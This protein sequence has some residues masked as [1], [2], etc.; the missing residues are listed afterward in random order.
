M[1]TANF[2]HQSEGMNRWNTVCVLQGSE[3]IKSSEKDSCDLDTIYNV[4]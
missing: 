4:H 2:K 1:K 3:G